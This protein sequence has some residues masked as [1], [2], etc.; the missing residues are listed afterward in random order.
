MALRF[1]ISDLYKQSLIGVEVLV[2]GFIF[3]MSKMDRNEHGSFLRIK[4]FDGKSFIMATVWDDSADFWLSLY[5]DGYNYISEAEFK[6]VNY[7]SRIELRTNSITKDAF[8]IKDDKEL[9]NRG[10]IDPKKTIAEFNKN[11]KLIA[12]KNNRNLL[13]AIIDFVKDGENGLLSM[14]EPRLKPNETPGSSYDTQ[15]PF[16]YGMISKANL[17]MDYMRD[18]FSRFPYLKVKL[19]TDALY[20]ATLVFFLAHTFL[21]EQNGGGGYKVSTIGGALTPEMASSILLS[22]IESQGDINLRVGKLISSIGKV[23]TI[24]NQKSSRTL[25]EVVLDKG[26]KHASS[27]GDILYLAEREEEVPCR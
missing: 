11:K 22:K 8:K 14:N 7:S 9:Y 10:F 5:E 17:A 21:F 23:P 15:F 26:I 16:I 19:D 1:S 13:D 20:I 24:P 25:E 27:M 18:L 4:L 6:V 3:S 2:N 12:E